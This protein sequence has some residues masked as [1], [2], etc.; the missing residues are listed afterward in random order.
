M[1]YIKGRGADGN[2]QNRYDPLFVDF[3]HIDAPRTQFFIDHSRSIVARNDSPDVG[4]TYSLNP[5]RGCEHGCVYCYARPTHEQLGFSAG[6]DFETKIMVKKDAPALLEKTFRS[7]SWQPQVVALSGNTDCYQ[8]TERRWKLTRSCLRVFLKY[9]NPVSITTKNALIVRDLDILTELAREH[10]VHVNLSLTTLDNRLCRILEPRTS[11]PQRRLEAIARL[12]GAGVPV[13][14]M[15]APVIPGINDREIAGIL[16][17]A[18][19]AGAQ[20]AGYILLRLPHGVKELFVNWLRQHF[21]DRANKVVHHI[22]SMRN[23]QLYECEFGARKR[24]HGPAAEMIQRLFEL[25]C[26]RLGLH[27]TLPPLNTDAFLRHPE[28][29]QLEL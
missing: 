26:R 2:P 6:L 12:S 25:S 16:S 13:G 20:N 23:G 21:P 14:V 7:P 15:V 19:A 4:F 29:A 1:N 22:Q 9:R 5:Y 17:E 3:D 18:A 10:L 27:Q 8:P 11:S 24:G 28:Q